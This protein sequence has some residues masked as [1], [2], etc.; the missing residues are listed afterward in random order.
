M[1]LRRSGL[2][3][4]KKISQRIAI[5]MGVGMGASVGLAAAGIAAFRKRQ[6]D[7][8]NQVV[9]ITGGSRGLGLA[10]AQEFG[11]RRCRLA[12]CARDEEELNR[13]RVQLES[14]GREVL[15]VPGDVSDPSSIRNMF[16][17]VREHYG[18][19][20]ILVNNAGQIRVGPL[21]N[22]TAADF[23]QALS[24]MFWGTVYS[25]LEVLPLMREQGGGRIVNVTSI[26][27]K[28]S[29]PHLLAYSCAKAAAIA[30]SEGLRS[31]ASR[32]GIHVTTVV[33]GL[34]RTGSNVNA[35]F[36][37][38][39]EEESA[40]FGIAAALPFLS[41]PASRAARGIVCAV[42]RGTSETILGIP[43]VVL[44]KAYAMCPGTMS[45][46]LTIVNSLLPSPTPGASSEETG[47]QLEPSHGS[48]YHFLTTLNRKAGRQL[49]Q[50]VA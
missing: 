16:T 11:K 36:K 49:N 24:V 3:H 21:G 48:L 43:A 15:T 33:P 31:E 27:G 23:E 10:I 19:I 29:T 50:P 38:K 35:I 41:I 34:M 8:T 20:D 9:L 25:T 14:A 18:R 7:L 47:L 37:G 17:A 45:R 1:K 2:M 32:D 4:F 30:F 5:G 28:V 46:V 13:A 6:I 39:Q 40:W 22:L 26:G 42:R 44:A 12:I